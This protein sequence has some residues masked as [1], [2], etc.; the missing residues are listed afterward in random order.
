MV[1]GMGLSIT[2]FMIIF[3]IVFRNK[4]FFFIQLVWLILIS[5]LNTYSADWINNFETFQVADISS[6]YSSGILMLLYKYLAIIAKGYA[7]NY[8]TFNFILTTISTLLIAFVI[9]RLSSSPTI[10][11]SFMFIYPFIDDIIQKRWYYAMGITVFGI[12]MS[13]HAKSKLNR[14]LILVLSA[15]LACQFHT[16]AILYFTLPIYLLLSNKIQNVLTVLVILLGTVARSRIYGIVSSFSGDA[17]AEKSNL[18][19]STLAANSTISHYIFWATWQILQAGIIFYIY[20]RKP[21]SQLNTSIWR[22]NMWALCLIPLY[23]FDPVF[24]RIFRSIL[25]FNYII[26]GNSFW[27]KKGAISKVGLIAFLIQLMMVVTSFYAFDLNS[28]L[29]IKTI[30]FDI[31]YNNQFLSLF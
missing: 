21:Q 30:V 27:F 18:Y 31:F 19:F 8:V 13:L 23:S 11:L 9:F 4:T 15:L 6:I 14:T 7:M 3:G 22:I 16:G 12:Y 1:V 24:S 5:G 26:I 25:V 29:G 20:K 28:S 17:M 2:L 10:V